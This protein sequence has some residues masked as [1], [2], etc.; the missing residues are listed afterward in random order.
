MENGEME[1]GETQRVREAMENCEAIEEVNP[2][3]F[4]EAN[5]EFRVRSSLVMQSGAMHLD[6]S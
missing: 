3:A 5:G 1:N 6:A 2:E 4:S